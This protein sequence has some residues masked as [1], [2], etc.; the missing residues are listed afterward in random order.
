MNTVQDQLDQEMPQTPVG[1]LDIL[2]LP[3]GAAALTCTGRTYTK[4]AQH[5][6]TLQSR[7]A[8]VLKQYQDKLSE[9]NPIIEELVRCHTGIDDIIGE[10]SNR[11]PNQTA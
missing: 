4:A 5:L 6:H 9:M 2:H 3:P 8:Q 1:V 7:R 10:L 11:N